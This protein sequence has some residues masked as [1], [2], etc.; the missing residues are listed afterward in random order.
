MEKTVELSHDT[1]DSKESRSDL[2]PVILM[3][4]LFWN[5]FML[6][7]IARD[8]SEVTQRKV[9]TPFDSFSMVRFNVV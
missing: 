9:K 1:F 6:R 5:K 7:D 8:L 2:C 3:H 4:G